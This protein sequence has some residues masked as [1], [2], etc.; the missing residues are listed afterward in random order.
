MLATIISILLVAIVVLIVAVVVR[1][2]T[3]FQ[4]APEATLWLQNH[5]VGG[6]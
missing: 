6:F 4:P 2:A 5:P 1:V 3:Y